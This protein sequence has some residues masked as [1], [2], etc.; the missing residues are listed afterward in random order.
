[1]T[2]L[3]SESATKEQGPRQQGFF[4]RWMDFNEAPIPANELEPEIEANSVASFGFFVMLALS[5]SLASLGLIANS[6]AVIIGA[7]IVAP[8]MNP[9]VAIGFS[10][11]RG[12][13]RLLLR[14]VV[15]VGVGVLLVIGIA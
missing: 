3:R 2:N 11:V 7:M 14:S 15:S 12:N 9:I 6:A 1:M 13:T 8:L 4:S 5:A 10:I